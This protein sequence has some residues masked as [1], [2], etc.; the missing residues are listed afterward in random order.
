M[1]TLLA[2]WENQVVEKLLYEKYLEGLKRQL[3]EEQLLEILI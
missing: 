2:L 3:P 1:G